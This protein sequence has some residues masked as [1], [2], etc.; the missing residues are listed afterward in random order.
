MNKVEKLKEKARI[1]IGNMSLE[2]SVEEKEISKRI[3][4]K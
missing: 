3:R 1:L 4:E 2:M